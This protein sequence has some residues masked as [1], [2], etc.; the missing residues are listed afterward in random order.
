MFQNNLLMAGG[1]SGPDATREFASSAVSSADASVYT[2]SSQD[3]GTAGATRTIIVFIGYHNSGGGVLSGVT[4]G[5]EAMSK[6]FAYDDGHMKAESWQ[7][8][9]P[10]DTSADIVATFTTASTRCGLGTW[11]AYDIGDY[12]DVDEAGYATETLPLTMSAGSV[13]IG[14]FVCH[15]PNTTTTWTNMTER[16]TTVMDYTSHSGADN[17]SAT[18]QT[19]DITCDWVG[20][21]SGP[22][23]VASWPKA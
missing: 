12:E 4:I 1:V 21:D 19:I 16:F 8:A 14:Y 6:N 15:T 23:I 22:F 10:D 9:Y 7:L 11:A 18:D 17:S 2:F 13:G 5:G 3:I 20:R